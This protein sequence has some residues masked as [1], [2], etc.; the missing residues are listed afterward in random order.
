MKWTSL[1]KKKEKKIVKDSW[2]DWLIN[3]IPKPIKN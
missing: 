1:K 2:F 3:Y